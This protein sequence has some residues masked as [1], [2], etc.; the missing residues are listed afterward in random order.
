MASQNTNNAPQPTPSN[1]QAAE[2][3]AGT[4][5]AVLQP[6]I[7]AIGNVGPSSA[8][9]V[10]GT[11]AMPGL[12]QYIRTNWLT[13]GT[14][15]WTVGLAAGDLL[16]STRIHPS[17]HPILSYLSGIHNT[18]VGGLEF[19]VKVAGTGFH[20]GAIKMCRIPPNRDPKEFIT[21]TETD[22]FEWGIIDPKTLEVVCQE[23]PDQRRMNYHYLND[24]TV[25]GFGG[26]FA[27]YVQIPLNTSASGTHQISVNVWCRASPTF[28]LLQVVPPPRNPSLQVN[29]WSHLAEWMQ[30]SIQEDF[31]C[32]S[33]K[34][35]ARTLVICD[36]KIVLLQRGMDGMRDGYG[37]LR[38]KTFPNGLQKRSIAGNVTWPLTP[39]SNWPSLGADVYILDW[40]DPKFIGPAWK[41]PFTVAAKQTQDIS[42]GVNGTL[43]N[44]TFQF[45]PDTEHSIKV[46]IVP[47]PPVTTPAP[48]QQQRSIFVDNIDGM[49]LPFKNSEPA[50][51]WK[52]PVANESLV[53]FSASPSPSGD[54]LDKNWYST[55]TAKMADAMLKFQ[56]WRQLGSN[57]AI[58]LQAWDSEYNLPLA[59]FKLYREGFMTSI[60]TSS[61]VLL[62][63]TKTNIVAV[64]TITAGSAIPS[65]PEATSYARNLATVQLTREVASLRA[66]LKN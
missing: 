4:D 59:T 35:G 1:G 5:P 25:D 29:S 16:W 47:V 8:A 55:Q 21:T 11:A 44:H 51:D 34:T 58:I 49:K 62:D 9:G 50:D 27:I 56:P 2:V 60:G 23:L 61:N 3:F 33:I 53:V 65:L 39:P 13:I 48:N 45:E 54:F 37:N 52:V 64:Q 32:N 40:K 31:C 43:G 66:Q 14:F 24:I 15:L 28:Q 26:Y 20:A 42:L 30:F 17:T 22:H 57:T 6:T 19:M 10:L 46:S 38:S 63:M 41:A 18:F 36:K 12:D 7:S